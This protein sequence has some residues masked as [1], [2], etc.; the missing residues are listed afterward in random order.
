MQP[1]ANPPTVLLSYA[2]SEAEWTE[3]W[4]MTQLEINGV[5]VLN[6]DLLAGSARIDQ[7]ANV[8]ERA[9]HTLLVLS[10]DWVTSQWE[11]FTGLISHSADPLG[12]Q[13]KTIP[14][15]R[16]HCT[17]PRSIARIISADFTSKQPVEW[18][19]QLLRLLAVLRGQQYRTALGPPLGALLGLEAPTNFKFPRNQHF[20]GRDQEL[21]ELHELLDDAVPLGVNASRPDVHTG[22]SLAG[23]TG[24]GGVGKTQ[25]VVEYI[26]RYWDAYPGGIFWINAAD[27]VADDFAEIGKR[28]LGNG[29]DKTDLELIRIAG[30]YLRSDPDTLLVLDNLNDL[31]LLNQAAAGILSPISLPCRL[32]FT[33]RRRDL[34]GMRSIAVDTL[35]EFESLKLLLRSRPEILEST[36]HEHSEAIKVCATLGGL[37][38]AIE[39]A[40]AY[41]EQE[42][43]VSLTGYLK[44]LGKEGAVQTLEDF[45][46]AKEW[47][48]TWH[49]PIQITLLSQ[50]DALVLPPSVDRATADQIQESEPDHQARLLLQTAA[51][52]PEAAAIPVARLSLLTGLSETAEEGYP[53]VLT[54]A[55]R[56]L[57]N[58]SLIE[59]LEEGKQVRLHPLVR[60]FTRSQI[61]VMDTFALQRS[62]NMATAL[63]DM[64]RVNREIL[65]RGVDALLGDLRSGL[66]LGPDIAALEELRLVLDKE[67]H[68]LRRP[69]S[70]M[71]SAYNLQQ[72]RKRAFSLQKTVLIERVEN[73][74]Y[75]LKI[76]WFRERMPSQ[77]ESSTL[78]RTIEGHSAHVNDV[79]ITP[80]GK[81]ALSAS[82]DKTLRLWDLETGQCI[83]TFEGHHSEVYSVVITPDGKRALSASADGTLRLWDLESGQSLHTFIEHT[84]SVSDVAITPDGKRALSASIDETL[85]LWDLETG[86]ILYT[87]E[88]HSRHVSAVAITRDGK[89]ALSASTDKTLRLWDLE[90]GQRILTLEGH[91]DYVV[92]VAITPDGKRALSGSWDYTLRLW[93]LE[94]G[95]SIQT[96]KGHSATVHAV[97]ITPDGQRALSASSDST[98]RLWNLESGQSICTFD[99]H[100]SYV[101]AVAI[102]TDG[103]RF[104]SGA[105]DNTLRLWD[106]ESDQSLHTTERHS[107]SVVAVAITPNGKRA[108]SASYDRTL[109][110]WD[111]ESGQ[112]LR[113]FE[114]H[115]EYVVTMALTADGKRALS[116]S[117]DDTLRLWDLESG[118]CIHTFRGH[119]HDVVAVAITPDGKRGL[120]ASS[121]STLRLWDLKTGQSLRTFKGHSSFVS[122]LAITPDGKRALSASGDLTLR[123][124]DLEDSKGFSISQ[125]LLPN[126]FRSL[127]TF[128]GHSGHIHDMAMTPDGK[129]AIS[130][131]DDKTLRLWDLENGQ[132]LRTLEGHLASVYSVAITPDGKRALSGSWDYTLRLWDLESGQSI[133]TLEGHSDYAFP[134]AVTPDGKRALS[135]S[136]DRTLRLWDLETGQLLLVFT[137]AGQLAAITPHYQAERLIIVGFARGR[138]HIIDYDYGISQIG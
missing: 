112:S 131:S 89:R 26:F 116:G 62:S 48:S 35:G 103:K 28:I 63:D 77:Q 67:A 11:A 29:H 73:A 8:A 102:T 129:R 72:I 126:P 18:E 133:H 75:S 58:Y 93:D 42:P 57:H 12:Q 21:A 20:V 45:E 24:L 94:S 119:S 4:L 25:L 27:G 74:L 76:P 135:S 2:P 84:H 90:T 60:E 113:S 31:S 53:A 97:A 78:V 128:K 69:F 54:S 59:K 87:L 55:L 99:G 1:P 30:D 98:L 81:H 61:A 32:L 100:S 64:L 34:R 121:D 22:P 138:P 38:L 49:D 36:H 71:F 37:P 92:A 23:L 39:M 111:L 80:D 120:S 14:L 17:P 95:Q 56:R 51:L 70:H 110:L 124:W 79:A 5:K 41:L 40:A 122:A 83:H 19:R 13:R 44:R 82:S 115:S 123:L 127:H 47:S 136:Y 96:F 88:G 132:C 137:D 16:Q 9:R 105:W 7:L 6:R 50:W 117:R 106:L 15:I 130:A 10:P 85:R 66:R 33:T 134:V 108:V 118:R 104:L 65:A 125:L 43:D 52:M 114:G 46:Q 107:G 3:N 109:R 68:N 91:S 101:H 86:Q